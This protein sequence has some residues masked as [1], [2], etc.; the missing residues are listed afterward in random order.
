MKIVYGPVP[1]WR[2]GKSLGIDPV[3]R[4]KKVCS[5]D[6]TYC[7]L[8]RTVV[9]TKKP[10]EFVK[11]GNLGE[12]LR[13]ALKKT[14]VDVVTFSGT[15][16]PTLAKN[17][18]RMVDIVKQTTELPV[19]ILTNSSML[20]LKRVRKNMEKIDIVI[21]KLDAASEE[22]F[23]NVNRP[24][25]GLTLK[26]VVNGIKKMRKEFKGKKFALQCMFVEENQSEAE[27]ISSLAREIEPDEIQIDTPLRPSPEKELSVKEIA[28]ITEKFTGLNAV[29]VYG[30]KKPVV[31]VLD[32]K[33]TLARRPKL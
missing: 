29:N 9:K 28:G 20:G 27:N 6:C 11:T 12:Q 3:C 19:A 25:D 10:V 30:M 17:L 5:F 21:A 4:K 8:G 22:T 7:Q 33:E 26:K 2:L 23:R 18:G 1:S 13:E 32:L 16:E 24:A 31:K 15:G 14:D